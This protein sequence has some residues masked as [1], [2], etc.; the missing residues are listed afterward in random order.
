[1]I[2]PSSLNLSTLPWVPLKATNG[3][4]DLIMVMTA[5]GLAK[6]IEETGELQQIAGKKLAY[7]DTDIHPDGQGSLKKRMEDE[8]ADVMAI[9]AFVIKSF[10]LDQELINQRVSTKLK[11]FEEWD[12]SSESVDNNGFDRQAKVANEI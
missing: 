2:D 12:S 1:M 4:E 6:L 11:R 8:I 3:V 10:D 7:Y 5:G 9:I